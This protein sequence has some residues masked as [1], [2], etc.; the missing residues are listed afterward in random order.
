MARIRTSLL[1]TTL[2]VVATVTAGF[3]G[4]VQSQRTNAQDQAQ[5]E[6]QTAPLSSGEVYWQGQYLQFS[7]GQDNAGQV[8]AIRRVQDGN[9]GQLATEVLLDGSGSAVVGTTNLDGQYVVV[10][11]NNEPV[12]FQNGTA[13]TAG[14]VSEASFEVAT[15]TLNAS[16]ADSTVTNDDSQ[17]A[18]TDLRLQSNRAG[19]QVVLSSDQLS[20]SQLQSVFSDVEVRDGRAVVT[21]NA[22]SDAVFDANFTG[23]SPGDYEVTVAT[24]DGTAQDT[25]AIS[26]REPAEGSAS[27]QNQTVVEQRGDVARF[28]VTFNGTD[29]ATVK[30]GSRQVNYLSQFTVTDQDGDGTATV[31]VN[32][33]TAGQDANASGISVAGEDGLSN[34][35]MLT[36]PIPGRLDA[37]NYPIQLSVGAQTTGVGV[38]QLQNRSS[39]SI[40]VWTAPD[41]ES[42]GNVGQITEVAS[43]SD[44]VAYQ[45]WAIVQVQ[46]SGLYGYVQNVSDLNNETTGLS[47]NLT[48][49]GEINVPDQEVPLDQANLIVDESG[50]QFFL[51]VDSNT[52]EPNATYRANFTVSEENPYVAR[53]NSTTLSTNFT[54]VPRNVTIDD[55]TPPATAN[56]TVSGSSTLAPGTELTLVAEST[57][58]TPFFQRTTTEVGQNGSWQATFDLSDVPQGTNFTVRV[59]EANASEIGAVG[60]GQGGAQQTTT[61]A[62]TTQATTTAAGTTA[63][64]TTTAATTTAAGTTET[65]VAAL[66]S[67]AG[68]GL[69]VSHLLAIATLLAGAAFAT[70][71]R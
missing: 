57:G 13:Q 24:A 27:L 70:R 15:Q 59:E 67:L 5:G 50:N 25:A 20:P 32:T 30:L 48:R 18:R 37:V 16:F 9:V 62:G 35:R 8:W 31:L 45:D 60:G 69:S 2:L 39:D 6:V 66:S 63:A 51:V 33:Y 10:N 29:R 4:A 68:T 14:S 58:G 52:L 11:Q 71:R 17:D 42:V 40:Q 36:D 64:E 53:G 38:L 3:T 22:S 56:A 49:V 65:T 19:Y 34:F 47:M 23:I 1:L 44:T 54:V 46:A 26:V 7:A 28:N 61:A 41:Q 21:R 12:V 43:Q 55:A